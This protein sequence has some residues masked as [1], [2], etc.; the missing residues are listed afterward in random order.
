MC[1]IHTGQCKSHKTQKTQQVLKLFYSFQSLD[2]S[3]LS[4]MFLKELKQQT[5]NFPKAVANYKSWLNKLLQWKST[6][7]TNNS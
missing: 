7:H 3:P 2:S 1:S 4:N 6:P 5:Y